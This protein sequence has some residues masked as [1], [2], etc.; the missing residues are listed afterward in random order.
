MVALAPGHAAAKAA[1][2]VVALGVALLLP[3]ISARVIDQALTTQGAGPGLTVLVTLLVVC[4]L[5]ESY[6]E[7]AG[8]SARTGALASLR[9]RMVSQVLAL[10][11]PGARR[12]ATG[13][14][15]TRFTDNAS[16][17]ARAVPEI[18]E[19]G[20]SAAASAG[21]LVALCLIDWWLGVAFLAGAL[22]TVLLLRHL[23]NRVSTSFGGYL[24]HLTAIAARLTDALAGRRTI[25]AAGTG[26]REV[27]RVLAPL[28]D[29]ST[30]GLRIWAVRRAVSW[31]VSFALVGVRVA[32]LGVAGLG[33]T[34]GR[35]SPG[36]LLAATLYVSVALGFVQQVDTLMFLAGARAHA[37]RV[38]ELLD[39]VPQF[40]PTAADDLPPGPRTLSFR[41]VS[42]RH[43]GRTVLDGLDL[44]VP[45]GAEIAVVGRSGTGKTTLSLLA[46]RLLEADE[47]A[48]FIDGARVD[49][50][51]PAALRRAVGYAFDR[52]VLL[53]RTV[54]DAL[55]YGR[56]GSS[57]A[58]VEHAALVAQ[59]WDFI[60]RLPEGLETQLADAPFSGG[61][62]QRLGLARAVVHGGCIL[63]LDDAMSSLDTI[64][65]ARLT[66]ALT[67][68]LPGRTRLLVANR[69]ASA[70]RA[71]FVAWL[72][73]GR[74]R[75][76]APHHILWTAEPAYRAVFAPPVLEEERCA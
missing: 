74:I 58:E 45:A 35:L 57:V 39:E 14:L 71:D 68:G 43:G 36:E 20:V 72:D 46:G 50:L 17:G 66:V 63:V 32:V 19:A 9:H 12:H 21:A 23:M 18:V 53:G 52:P 75:A 22:P 31:Q 25:R 64:T 41:G 70:A 13:D 28:P 73:D 48:V 49:T 44:D 26:L 5:A 8:V 4:T 3:V 16:T 76:V 33:V 1:C 34:A 55:T 60:Q 47:G 40:R 15:V 37:G 54:R 7:V 61:E 24:V 62:L 6:G 51:H 59:A 56:P 27:E 2:S 42:V 69:V 29:L 38:L 11:V 65:E 67:E 10:G 30:A